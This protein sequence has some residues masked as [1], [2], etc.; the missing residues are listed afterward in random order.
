M[1]S[2][3]HKS[4]EEAYDQ[5]LVLQAQAADEK[6][7]IELVERWIPRLKRHAMRLTGRPDAAS[8]V[9]QEAW[10]AIVRGLGRLQDPACFRR[11][12]YQIVSRR[13]ADWVRKQQRIRAT[14]EP[15]QEDPLTR[16]PNDAEDSKLS[17]LQQALRE[18]PAKDRTLLAMHYLEEMSIRE[19]A[20]AF[21]LPEG[22]VKSR[23][24]HSRQRLKRV[25]TK[26]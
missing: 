12:A 17:A 10:L 11:W 1:N 9:S 3:P 4:S 6:A 13:C 16:E 23:L 2:K 14:T 8:D 20:E 25:I 24:F 21:Q 22:T 18:L 19:I 15:I 26:T 7:L 5:W